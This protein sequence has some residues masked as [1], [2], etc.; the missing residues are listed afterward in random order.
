M[1]EHATPFSANT[2]PADLFYGSLKAIRTHSALGK[3]KKKEK[4]T[5]WQL[6]GE[7]K[8]GQSVLSPSSCWGRWAQPWW[9][10]IPTVGILRVYIKALSKAS[11]QERLLL[12][13]SALSSHFASRCQWNHSLQMSVWFVFE[14]SLD[15]KKGGRKK[16]L[17]HKNS[18]KYTLHGFIWLKQVLHLVFFFIAG[19]NN[20]P[21]NF[22]RRVSKLQRVQ[23]NWGHFAPR[24]EKHYFP[25]VEQNGRQ[26]LQTDD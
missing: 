7:I 16:K 15:K 14:H 20:C 6:R 5:F 18:C 4:K 25:L 13:E 26:L 9:R 21:V 19:K 3:K 10:N 2:T 8:N 12:K 1:L 11:E 24:V 22:L 17:Y 23:E